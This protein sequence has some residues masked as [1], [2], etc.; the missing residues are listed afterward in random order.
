VLFKYKRDK[1]NVDRGS[2][3]FQAALPL[4]HRVQ[5]A[6]LGKGPL[7]L[8][9]RCVVYFRRRLENLRV[10]FHSAWECFVFEPR[11]E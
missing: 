1:W 10:A 9:F 2:D 11:R 3:G 5:G 8:L 7:V 6:G 4:E